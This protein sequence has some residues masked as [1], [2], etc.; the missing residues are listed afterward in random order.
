MIYDNTDNI[1]TYKDLSP[2]ISFALTFLQ[3]LN[4]NIKTGV[5]QITPRVK[6][7]ESEYETKVKNDVGFEAHRKNI[8]IRRSHAAVVCR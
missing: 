3:H 2:D 7:I 8:D 4:H 5:Y 1:A 6:A